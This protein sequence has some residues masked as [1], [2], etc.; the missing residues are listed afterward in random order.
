MNTGKRPLMTL[1]YLR[2]FL[3]N[4]TVCFAESTAKKSLK[5]GHIA[6]IATN[7]LL[8]EI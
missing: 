5:Q 2:P 1:H 6:Y 7:P 4:L 8:E 3:H